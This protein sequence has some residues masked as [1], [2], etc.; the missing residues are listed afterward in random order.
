MADA[1]MQDET[2]MKHLLKSELTTCARLLTSQKED[3]VETVL[4]TSTIQG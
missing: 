3:H 2:K 1:P 4:A